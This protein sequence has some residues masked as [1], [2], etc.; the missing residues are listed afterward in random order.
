MPS[1]EAGDRVP[2]SVEV[3]D[4]R[5]FIEV[6]TC[7]CVRR[8]AGR[9]GDD[10]AC[11]RVR[12]ALSGRRRHPAL[13]RGRRRR[14]GAGSGGVRLRAPS[15]PRFGAHAFG[16]Q[17]VD[18]FLANVDLPA[19]FFRGRR[20]VDIGC[21]SGRWTY[22]LAELGAE[23]VAVDLTS[24]GVESLYGELGD[25]PNV[26]IA[27]A[28]IFALPFAPE[29]FDFVMSWGVLHHTPSTKQAFDRIVPLV[30]PDGTLYVMIY[31]VD[32][33][34]PTASRTSSAGC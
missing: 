3:V 20:C 31:D 8:R 18:Q 1:F 5:R 13:R 27:Q 25:R 2:R 28:D 29:T 11:T 33:G 21:G 30:R 24:G 12:P 34:R 22:A 16:P 23:V 7:P 6:F 14:A 15:I 32:Q 26:T 19:E 9:P 4:E 17:L 10:L